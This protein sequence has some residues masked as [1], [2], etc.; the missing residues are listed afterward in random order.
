MQEFLQVAQREITGYL[1]EEASISK[2]F[3]AKKKPQRLS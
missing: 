2:V 3:Q 1:G